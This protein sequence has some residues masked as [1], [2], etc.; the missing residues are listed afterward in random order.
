MHHKS[1]GQWTWKTHLFIRLVIW[2]DNILALP[3]TSVTLQWCFF[4]AI[5]PFTALSW[6]TS[7]SKNTSLQARSR[8]LGDFASSVLQKLIYCI[9][10]GC[11]VLKILDNALKW[12]IT[13]EYFIFIIWRLF[14]RWVVKLYS[15]DISNLV[16][17]D[18][19]VL[20]RSLHLFY[21][22]CFRWSWNVSCISYTTLHSFKF[23]LFSWADG[24]QTFI[25][26]GT[27]NLMFASWLAVED[28][29]NQQQTNIWNPLYGNVSCN[30][31]V[32]YIFE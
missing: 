3:F 26:N 22:M 14:L 17:S 16:C 32:R 9:Y 30:V 4:S 25:S 28:W 19:L 18:Y 5:L 11:G 29:L 6:T 21:Y 7:L 13:Y 31:L 27:F 12:L 2:P 24:D 23:T 15:G 1:S 10:F 20:L 8:S